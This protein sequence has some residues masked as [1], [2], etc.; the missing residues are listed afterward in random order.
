MAR[1]LEA[2][3]P[4]SRDQL[5]HAVGVHTDLC[6]CVCVRVCVCVKQIKYM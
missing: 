2:R 4:V 3:D 6:V 1:V 5:E